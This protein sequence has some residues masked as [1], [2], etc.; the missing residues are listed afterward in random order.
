MRRLARKKA[1]A[2][3]DLFAGARSKSELVA[4]FLAVLQLVKG[5][6][7]REMCIRDRPHPRCRSPFLVGP[8]RHRSGR[9]PE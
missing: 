7:T 8:V 4:T 9:T 5:K 6:R 2:Y 1:V 3:D